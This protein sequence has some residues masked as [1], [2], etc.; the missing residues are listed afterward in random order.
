MWL[1]NADVSMESNKIEL[2][3]LPTA[4]VIEKLKRQPDGMNAM[5]LVSSWTGSSEN[6]FTV[7]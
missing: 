3:I 7:A 5:L 2:S 6:L 4:E 1:F